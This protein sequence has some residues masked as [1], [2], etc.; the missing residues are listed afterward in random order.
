M[1]NIEEA[2]KCTSELYADSDEC[3][4]PE[5]FFRRKYNE[6]KNFSSKKLQ[7]LTNWFKKNKEKYWDTKT[8][9]DNSTTSSYTQKSSEE[10]WFWN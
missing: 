9:N 6:L 10:G 7:S 2:K 8:N 4:K 3:K 5:G 1:E